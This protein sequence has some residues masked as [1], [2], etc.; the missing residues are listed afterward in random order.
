MDGRVS[1]SRRTRLKLSR[2]LQQQLIEAITQKEIEA[3]N[4]G[5]PIQK[6]SV[7]EDHF[8]NTAKRRFDDIS[9]IDESAEP[10]PKR[11]RPAE[12]EVQQPQPLRAKVSYASF[13]QDF[14]D[15]IPHI[16]DHRGSVNIPE[17][18]ESLKTDRQT[19]CRSDGQLWYPRKETVSRRLTASVLEMSTK[20]NA[21]G[22]T[23]SNKSSGS[24]GDEGV[25]YND[26]SLD[27]RLTSTTSDKINVDSQIYR[28]QNLAENGIYLQHPCDPLPKHIIDLI[29]MT[30]KDRGSL[31]PS[32]NIA[33][34]DRG[35]YDL[36]LG[37]SEP[38]V[39]SYLRQKL[40]PVLELQDILMRTLRAQMIRTVVPN[41]GFGKRVCTPIPD[42]L[43]GYDSTKAFLDRRSQMLAAG[44][45]VIGTNHQGS[46]YPFFLVEFKGETSGSGSFFGAT[47]Q[48]LGGSATCV[49]SCESL[50][51]LLKE[52]QISKNKPEPLETV[53][54]SAV[55]N[56]TE[57]RVHVSWKDSQ[58][59]YP[60]T[61]YPMAI[62][63]SFLLHKPA[64][65]LALSKCI[66]NIRDWVLGKRLDHIREILDAII[67]SRQLPRTSKAS[68]ASSNRSDSTGSRK[69]RKTSP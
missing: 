19:H 32:S 41:A 21:D 4:P 28:W 52:S 54:F 60:M 33:E 58:K 1:K 68:P 66:S 50:N 38:D 65:L 37:A 11:A 47:N 12:I 57:V 25:S 53:V 40:F 39:E 45:S 48:C 44:I 30:R 64:D 20:R 67:E 14:I 34:K 15:P 6:D 5:T 69:S 63:D 51:R 16:Y 13:L 62:V 3:E 7:R 18:L 26:P 36:Q 27:S 55:T 23:A 24:Q 56:G 2:A 35:L 46:I 29:T 42:I 49:N 10:S 31:N 59:G 8:R 17:W 61:R 22:S 43:Y 9:D